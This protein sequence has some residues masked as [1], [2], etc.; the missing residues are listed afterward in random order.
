[1][2]GMDK[3]QRNGPGCTCRRM[4][5]TDSI[6]VGFGPRALPA[7]RWSRRIPSLLSCF[8]KPLAR[9]EARV[10]P[11]VICRRYGSVLCRSVCDQGSHVDPSDQI[12]VQREGVG[13][14]PRLDRPASHGRP[15]RWYPRGPPLFHRKQGDL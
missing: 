10:R 4:A 9:H 3:S 6:L 12:S 8:P 1:M 14:S 5:Q 15:W 13:V 7:W 11:V 2:S